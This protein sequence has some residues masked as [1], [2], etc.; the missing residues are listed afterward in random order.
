M[1][2][3]LETLKYIFK[4]F[5]YVVVFALVP[6]IFFSLTLSEEAVTGVLSRL[7]SGDPKVGFG[8]VFQAISVF[9][10]SSKTSVLFGFFGILACVLCVSMLTAFLEKH[11]RIGKRTLNGLFGKVNDNLISTCGFILLC[12][13]VY[14][15]WAVLLAALCYFVTLV[16]STTIAYAA[17]AVVYFV[18]HGVLL[19]VLSIFYLWLPCMQITGFRAFEALRYSY[20][21]VAPIQT[22]LVVNQ[23]AFLL[24]CE[25]LIGATVV[26]VSGVIA[27][28]VAA[29]VLYTAIIL[30]YGV[31]ML[32]VYF[33]LAQVERADLKKYYR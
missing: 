28:F 5:L 2:Y 23:L 32:I 10:F 18:M 14:E 13:V 21:L 25:A 17:L 30:I 24:V 31:R 15:I 20:Q 29:T 6:A 27:S 8:E 7:F 9:N 1:N 26:F 11:M 4:N 19:Y 33:D 22:K 3:T 16:P 12:L